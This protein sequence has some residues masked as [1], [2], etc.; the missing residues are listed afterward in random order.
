[1]E[2]APQ[3]TPPEANPA[4]AV[5]AQLV[6]EVGVVRRLVAA[7]DNSATLGEIVQRLDNL[8]DVTRTL[9]RRPAMTLT[10]D[11]MAEQI[12]SAAAKARAEDHEAMK[13][14][15]E[16]MEK[17]ARLMEGQAARTVTAREQRRNLVWTGGGGLLA[18]VMLWS[19]L[20]G[21]IVRTAPASWHWPERMAAHVMRLDRWSAG[22]RLLATADPDHWRAIVLGNGIVQDNQEAIA[23]CLRQMWKA[24]KTVQCRVRVMAR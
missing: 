3:P 2:N 18:G 14:A 20:P 6:E 12:A 4:A 23:V 1:M 21:T 19:F 15:R 10:P 11:K 22:E 9:S 8:T 24:G 7:N 13:Q 17:A 16:R 5:F